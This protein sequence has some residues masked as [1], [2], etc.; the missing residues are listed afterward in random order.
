MENEA[1]YQAKRAGIGML[2]SQ[3]AYVLSACAYKM[4][5]VLA[6]IAWNNNK[7]GISVPPADLRYLCGIS[8]YKVKPCIKELV[9]CCFIE[10]KQANSKANHEIVVL[11]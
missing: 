5:G 3:D 7:R 9:E 11:V 6:G 1:Q 10:H 8:Y 2:S 4:L